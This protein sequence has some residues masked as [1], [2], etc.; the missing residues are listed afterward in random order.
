MPASKQRADVELQVELAGEN[1]RRQR[2]GR[3]QFE[4]DAGLGLMRRVA[5]AGLDEE[6][7]DAVRQPSGA[8]RQCAERMHGFCRIARLFQ[9]FPACSRSRRPRLCPPCRPAIPR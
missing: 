6:R 1:Q 3:H 4:F 9:E 8:W 5:G 2:L 7:M